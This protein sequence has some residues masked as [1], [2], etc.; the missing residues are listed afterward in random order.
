MF[1]PRHSQVFI[2]GQNGSANAWGAFTRR[3]RL[4]QW[5]ALTIGLLFF[6]PLAVLVV[7]LALVLGVGLTVIALVGLGIQRVRGLFSGQRI[8]QPVDQRENVRIRRVGQ[9]ADRS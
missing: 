4:E 8:M 2:L 5:L 9:S 7:S 6:I 3:S 1:N